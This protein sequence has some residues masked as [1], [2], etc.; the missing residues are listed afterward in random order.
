MKKVIA[1]IQAR[2]TSKRF[3]GKVLKKINKLSIVQ[4]I[5]ERLKKSKQLD[6]IIFC[7]P[8]N[9]SNI[10]LERHLRNSKIKVFKGPENDV[11]KRFYLTAKKNK[12]NTVVRITADCPFVD[13][14]LMDEMLKDFKRF[15]WT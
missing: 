12:A 9:R 10:K 5:N 2:S 7:I 3:K 11:L 6:D 8:N 4:L 14:R 15:N 13:T 1:I